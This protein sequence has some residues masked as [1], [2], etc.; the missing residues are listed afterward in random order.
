MKQ[1]LLEFDQPSKFDKL[2]KVQDKVDTVRSVMDENL[3]HVLA[4]GEDLEALEHK[5]KS[6]AENAAQFRQGAET[7]RNQ[8]WWRNCKTIAIVSIILMI[9]LSLLVWHFVAK[10]GT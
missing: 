7:L 10:A 1:L 2:Y 3:K 4:N 6:T 9:T 8:Q 5:S